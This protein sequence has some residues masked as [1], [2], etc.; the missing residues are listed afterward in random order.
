MPAREQQPRGFPF[1]RP[2]LLSVNAKVLAH[3]HHEQPALQADLVALRQHPVRVR[4]R[5]PGGST[6]IAPKV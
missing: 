5:M 4:P 1:P 2:R 3:C 6:L